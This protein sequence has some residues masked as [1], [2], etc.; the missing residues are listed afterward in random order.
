M[1]LLNKYINMFILLSIMTLG[2][3]AVFY[4]IKYFDSIRTLFINTKEPIFYEAS[5]TSINTANIEKR[6]SDIDTVTDVSITTSNTVTYINIK[7]IKNLHTANI[8]IL[9]KIETEL[10]S[11]LNNKNVNK[12]FVDIYV[13]DNNAN[14]VI[15]YYDYNNNK[16]VWK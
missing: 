11:E 6:L 13:S 15:G 1:K 3:F 16:V 5:K 8:T 9:E 4:S 2:T 14:V 12:S 10:V 7:T